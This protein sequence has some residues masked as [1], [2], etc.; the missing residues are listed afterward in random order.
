MPSGTITNS[1]AGADAPSAISRPCRVRTP[2]RRFPPTPFGAQPTYQSWTLQVGSQW[3][4]TSLS[5]S[6]TFR[7]LVR[8]GNHPMLVRAFQHIQHLSARRSQVIHCPRHC[9]L[10]PAST[11]AFSGFAWLMTLVRMNSA[12]S[13]SPWSMRLSILVEDAPVIGIHEGVGAALKLVVDAGNWTRNS[14]SRCRRRRRYRSR[15]RLPSACPRRPSPWPPRCRSWPCGR[16]SY[17]CAASRPGR[18]VCRRT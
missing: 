2:A 15:S 8:V 17:P 4:G 10:R 6:F 9:A 12:F 7:T 14:R 13:H 3:P 11:I 1:F 16:H 18:P 5:L